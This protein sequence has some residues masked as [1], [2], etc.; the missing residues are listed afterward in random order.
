MKPTPGPWGIK[1][2]ETGTKAIFSGSSGA[3]VAHTVRHLSSTQEANARLIAAAPDLLESIEGL[4]E[5]CESMKATFGV[6]RG[7]TPEHDDIYLHEKWAE[8]FMEEQVQTARKAIAKA[9]GEQ[10]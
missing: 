5:A 2:T 6:I 9:T 8:E 7:E 3:W 1:T 10:Q 4:I